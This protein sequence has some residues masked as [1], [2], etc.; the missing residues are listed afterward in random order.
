MTGRQGRSTHLHASAAPYAVGD[1]RPST[2]RSRV[3]LALLA[4]SI[5]SAGGAFGA[6][7]GGWLDALRFR[8][9]FVADAERRVSEAGSRLAMKLWIGYALRGFFLG[10]EVVNEREFEEFARWLR[11]ADGEVRSCAFVRSAVVTE[12]PLTRKYMV[13]LRSPA[14]ADLGTGFETALQSAPPWITAVAIAERNDRPCILELLTMGEP[15][16]GAPPDELALVLPLK[17]QAPEGRLAKPLGLIVTTFRAS[18]LLRSTDGRN[19]AGS[20]ARIFILDPDR[21]AGQRVVVDLSRVD[22]SPLHRVPREELE[23]LAARGDAIGATRELAPSLSKLRVVCLD[24]S[25]DHPFRAERYCLAGT[26]LGALLTSS[27]WLLVKRRALAAERARRSL[28]ELVERRTA[29]LEIANSDL[30]AF[31][32]TVSH[33]LRAP[34]RAIEGYAEALAETL[35]TFADETQRR[36]LTTLQRSASRAGEI[37]ASLLSLSKWTRVPLEFR[38]LD[39]GALARECGEQVL[40]T[41]PQRRIELI[42]GDLPRVR[43]DEGLLR[44]VFVNLISNAVKYTRDRSAARIEVRG[45]MLDDRVEIEVGDNGI[46]IDANLAPRLF[47]PF[48]RLPNASDYEGSGIGLSLV[49]RI[50]SRHGGTI[51]AEGKLGVGATIRFTLPRADGYS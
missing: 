51:R 30:E 39:T 20:N 6:V 45:S 43:G 19:G 28:E 37:V 24:P 1:G 8:S 2:P 31:A 17:S 15:P 14:H 38:D 27:V 5:V 4:I 11:L 26:L 32:H 44:Q 23:R 22:E 29:D 3:R 16:P 10:S 34:L 40:S 47:K 49:A 21:E 12:L 9:R 42:V 25:I 18:D 35:G 41:H 46:G 50:I 33:D 13:E 36:Q 7:F 48:Q